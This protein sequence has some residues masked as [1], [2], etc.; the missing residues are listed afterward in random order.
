MMAALPAGSKGQMV[1]PAS[2]HHRTD[3]RL[4]FE[5]P[6]LPCDERTSFDKEAAQNWSVCTQLT[7]RRTPVVSGNIWRSGA[8]LG[9]PVMSWRSLFGGMA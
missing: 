2:A 7:P 1:N 4:P 8:F 5:R 3:C 6:V 9:L